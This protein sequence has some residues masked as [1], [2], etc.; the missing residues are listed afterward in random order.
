MAELR[1]LSCTP[2]FSKILESSVLSRLKEE[3]TLSERQ[4]GGIKGCSTEHFLLETWN[5]IMEALEGGDTAANLV[6]IDFEKAFNRMDHLQCLHALSNMGASIEAVG[7]TA[8]F[9]HNRT[10]AVRIRL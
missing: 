9:L 3:V 4:F 5:Q 10:M 7:W 2:L 6:S 1:N 8:A